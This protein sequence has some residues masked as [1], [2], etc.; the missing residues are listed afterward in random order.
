MKISEIVKKYEGQ[1]VELEV[2]E[3]TDPFRKDIHTD[4]IALVSENLVDHIMDRDDIDIYRYELMDDEEYNRTIDANC[5]HLSFEDC[6]G[7]ANAKVLVIILP[8]NWAEEDNE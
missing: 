3:F 6:Y 8:Y 2:Y 1:Y 4:F 5:D 7:N